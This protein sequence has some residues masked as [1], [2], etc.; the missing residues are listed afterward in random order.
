MNGN[1]AQFGK[2]LQLHL[3]RLQV[4][5]NNINGL[6]AGGAGASEAEFASRL[7]ELSTT[8]RDC[9]E[10]TSALRRTLKSGLEQDDAIASETVS[11]WIGRRQSAQLHVRADAIEQLA[12]VAVE[13][14]A[15]SALEAEHIT[16]AALLAR[17]EAI[18]VQIQHSKREL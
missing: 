5:L 11:R 12:T 1:L 8:I 2:D 14:A 16:M 3:F 4:S 10:R 13:L 7:N 9:S 15:F 17:R 6:F 18:S